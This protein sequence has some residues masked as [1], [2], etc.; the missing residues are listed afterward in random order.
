MSLD[1]SLI[2]LYGYKLE[3]TPITDHI[4]SMKSDNDNYDI[5]S[6]L[7]DIY[8][9]DENNFMV[10]EDTMCGDYEYVGINLYYK[11]SGYGESNQ[12]GF[13]ANELKKLMDD[14][15]LD[16]CIHERLPWLIGKEYDECGLMNG[17][18]PKLWIIRK[19]W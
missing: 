11:S 10:C 19:V 14:E 15:L 13:E 3:N 8:N 4:E 18:L 6:A 1:A 5:C 7:D 9:P 17:K 2:I 12:I 16:K